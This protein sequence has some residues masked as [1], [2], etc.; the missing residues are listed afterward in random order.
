MFAHSHEKKDVGQK[1]ASQH[2]GNI[3]NQSWHEV[4]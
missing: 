2:L 3:Y 1:S 4:I